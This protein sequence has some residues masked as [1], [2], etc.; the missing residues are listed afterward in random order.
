MLEIAQP[1]SD[2]SKGAKVHSPIGTE[3]ARI[4]QVQAH[5]PGAVAVLLGLVALGAALLP[6]I[7]PVARHVNTIAHEAGHATMASALGRRVVGVTMK[8]DGSGLTEVQLGEKA[9]SVMFQLAGYLGPSVFGLVAAKLI[10]LGHSIA[11]LWLAML[12]LLCMLLVVRGFGLLTVIGS[13]VALYVVAADTSVGA[14]VMTAYGVAWFLLLSGVRVISEHG[15][16]AADADELHKL[17][18]VPRGFWSFV[19]LIGSLAALCVGA[20]LLV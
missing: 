6:A 5:L 16:T 2:V 18:K 3:L 20:V 8:P 19:W 10:Q 4:G 11:V 14:Q 15:S 13:G 9:G 1:S 7:W 12:L 17:T